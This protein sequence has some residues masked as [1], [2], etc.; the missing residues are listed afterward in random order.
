MAVRRDPVVRV[1]KPYQG[2]K[3]KPRNPAHPFQL[4]TKP[5]Q[6]QPFM[7]SP[8]LPGETLTN[9][10]LQSRVVTK[11]IKHPLV[12]WWTEYFFFYVKLKDIQAH[13]EGPNM[14]GF[15]DEMVTAPGTYDPAPLR[16][17]A[18]P[19]YYHAGGTPWAKY[20]MRTVVEYYFR[21]EGED[22]D[23][24]L[25]DGLPIAQYSGKNYTDS[26]TLASAKRTDRDVNLDLN[27]DGN[28]TVQEMY[29][30]QS[31][32]QAL[33]DAG[34]ETLDYEDWLRTFGVQA[35]EEV[36]ESFNRYRP[37]LIR[38]YRN[39]AYPTNTVEPTTGVPSSAVSW[40]N[41]FRA[42]KN[43]R[44][45]EPG[46]IIGLNVTKPKVYLKDAKG[47]LAS[48]ME[49]LENWLPALSHD[50]YEKGFLEFAANAGPLGGKFGATPGTEGYWLDLRDLLTHGDQFV[51]FAL[52]DVSSAL[53]V[54]TK[55]GQTR[56][57]SSAEVDGLFTGDRKSVV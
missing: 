34:L 11:P 20:A 3:R 23:H 42:D 50:R 12:G 24:A 17:A 29:D 51:N 22:W 57:P 40:V 38:F 33:R 18:D 14:T 5:F 36:P 16:A 48:Y 43:R 47:S 9:L 15:V 21:D 45:Q 35:P 19:K 28:I 4:R 41:A 7:L 13:L 10:V 46:F 37:E 1:A 32:W 52:D 8:V 30:A 49:V 27:D 26:L 53:S 2:V 55:D 54:I 25:I 56:Y 39:W 31:E 44:F 6:I